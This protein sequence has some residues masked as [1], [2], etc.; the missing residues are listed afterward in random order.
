MKQEKPIFEDEYDKGQGRLVG[1]D[2]DGGGLSDVYWF[3][4]DFR[5]DDLGFR[6]LVVFSST[7]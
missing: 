7:K 1:G 6:P 4:P 5:N 2:S 3:S